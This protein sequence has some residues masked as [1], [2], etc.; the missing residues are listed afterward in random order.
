MNRD[1]FPFHHNQEGL[2]YCLK[3]FRLGSRGH[4]SYMLLI[5]RNFSNDLVRFFRTLI[6]GTQIYDVYFL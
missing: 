2:Q 3:C 6:G 1:S 5:F 4:S